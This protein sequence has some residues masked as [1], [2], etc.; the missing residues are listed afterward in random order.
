MTTHAQDPA[1]VGPFA[2]QGRLGRGAMG[3]VYLARSPGGRL[4]AVKVVR[5]EL[6]GDS[7]FRAR[8]AREIDAARRVSGAFTAAVVDA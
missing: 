1:A 5:D 6:A 2:I 7:G 3:A 8:F 4:V